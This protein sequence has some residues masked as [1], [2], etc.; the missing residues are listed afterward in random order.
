MDKENISAQKVLSDLLDD[1]ESLSTSNLTYE[2]LLSL[3]DR[4]DKGI[5]SVFVKRKNPGRKAILDII[6]TTKPA[7]KELWI[8][9]HLELLN[10]PETKETMAYYRYESLPKVVHCLRYLILER[11]KMS[12]ED[13]KAY[14]GGVAKF[15]RDNKLATAC[16]NIKYT[17]FELV[18]YAVFE[19]ESYPE[20]FRKPRK[21]KLKE[22][23]NA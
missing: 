19:W 5:G 6:H 14:P 23:N 16:R 7:Y 10:E 21:T 13:L 2:D 8:G 20:E 4:F 15:L 12:K 22:E 1:I 11:Y 17:G 18:S 9:K 3:R